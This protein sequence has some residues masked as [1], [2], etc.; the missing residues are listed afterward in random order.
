MSIEHSSSAKLEPLSRHI[1]RRPRLEGRKMN[2]DV[3]YAALLAEAQATGTS[4][5]EWL[6]REM[7]CAWQDA[8]LRMSRRPANI[9]VFS[10]G[11]FDYI[12]DYYGE[13]EM[14]GAVIPDGVSESR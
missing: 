12:Y 13:L 1:K 4:A 14:A 9:L 10:H 2:L 5:V 6:Q 3:P 7:P 8:Y 11:T